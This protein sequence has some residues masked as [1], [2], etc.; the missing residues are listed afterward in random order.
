M[1]Y[2][3][4][5]PFLLPLPQDSPKM[6]ERWVAAF[7]AA[8]WDAESG[9]GLTKPGGGNALQDHPES[10]KDFSYKKAA[11][12]RRNL[13]EMGE[14]GIDV[15]LCEFAGNEV[16]VKALVQA[17]AEA[18]KERKR[19]PR[20][21]PVTADLPAAA[22]FLNAIPKENL[23]TTGGRKLVWLLPSKSAQPVE[24]PEMFVVGD[25]AWKPHLVATLGGAYAGPRDMEVVT[26]GPGYCDGT[27][28]LQ[29]RDDG[30]WYE[31]SWYAALKI[32]P[33]IVAIESWN[34]FDEGS[35]IC[36]TKDHGRAQ[37]ATTKKYA[38]QFRRG[39]EIA[40]PKGK[41]SSAIGVSY[42]LK[43][44][45]PNEGLRPVDSP[46]T[47]FEVVAL[48]GQS[49][50]MA[51]PVPGKD[52]R[53]LAFEIDDSYAYYERREY[54]VQIQLLDKG[55]GQVD[56][57]YDAALPAKGGR[58]RTRRAAEPFYFV[59]TGNWATATFKLPEAAFANR[60]EGGSDF[61]LVTK[62]RGLSIRWVQ[63]RAK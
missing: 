17:L 53:T 18:S 9:E 24:N 48:S 27:S 12:H 7:Y 8:R 58:D 20:V 11:W 43:F 25:A 54:E 49:L 1:R 6:S 15:A 62:G 31:R 57:E 5:L 19:I 50:L 38:D 10:F 32:K 16:A 55:R 41:Y 45:P 61:R 40:R 33:R 56:L 59:D 26:L 4:F 52:T 29:S 28:L 23:A 3:F 2:L 14:A 34:R 42:H 35:T 63:V 36:P 46:D 37:L 39:E 30:A 44:D 51:K 47:P 60:Q 21:A 22:A 13:E